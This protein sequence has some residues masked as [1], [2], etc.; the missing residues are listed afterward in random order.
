MR[1]EKVQTT[2]RL[3]RP[4]YEEASSFVKSKVSARTLN[5]FF[6]TAIKAY[7]RMLK[8]RQIDAAFSTMAKDPDYQK[9]ALKISEEF[10]ESDWE[11]FQ[12]SEKG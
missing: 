11:A 10:A 6:V 3:P 1:A 12:L 4:L 5:D 2:I 8:R 9:E 7:V